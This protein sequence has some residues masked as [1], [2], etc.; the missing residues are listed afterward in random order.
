MAS[1]AAP[2]RSKQDTVLITGAAGNLGSLL[3]RRLLSEPI[4]LRLMT[5]RTALPGD[6]TGQ[7]RIEEV[8]A[9]LARPERLIRALTGVD[10]V[11]HFSGALFRPRPARFLPEAKP[12]AVATLL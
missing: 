12:R 1:E 10:C 5:H 2:N 3:A 4:N 6:L 9:D 7:G 8:R 11:A